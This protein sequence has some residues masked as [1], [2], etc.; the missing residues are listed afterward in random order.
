MA[1][2][3]L[4][5][6]SDAAAA[7]AV[8]HDGDTV[9]SAGYGGNGTPHQLFVAL[10]RRFLDTGSPRGLT[11]VFSTGQGDMKEK[12]LNRLAHEGLVKRVIGGYFGLSPKLE[13]LIVDNRIEAYNL[14]EGVLT[15]LYR[16]IG[17]SKPGTLSPVGLGTYVD[18]R[19]DGGRM[20]SVTTE[21]LAQLMEIDGEEVLFYR[22]FPI[23]VA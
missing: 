8:I 15:H 3:I 14:P 22:A 5:K 7:V 10:E 11:L 17:A 4:K 1:P 23:H 13:R 9:A 16:D 2:I 19:Q 21:E 18:P 6:I 12:G 20:N